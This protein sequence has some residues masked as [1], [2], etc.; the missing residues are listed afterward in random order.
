VHWS[1]FQQLLNKALEQRHHSILLAKNT[2][3]LHHKHWQ[4]H[5][6][7]YW[8]RQL[9]YLKE[10]LTVCDKICRKLTSGVSITAM[11]NVFGSGSRADF[12]KSNRF[13]VAAVTN[14]AS[15]YGAQITATRQGFT[16]HR[17]NP[18]SGCGRW[19]YTEEVTCQQ[20]LANYQGGH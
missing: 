8:V 17:S 20:S 15:Q 18:C 16:K 5:T 13:E 6:G 19:T 1:G 10:H 14:V 4:W 12:K 3:E 9:D 11:L 2:T 7:S